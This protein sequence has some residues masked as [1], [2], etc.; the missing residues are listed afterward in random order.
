MTKYNNFFYIYPPRPKNAVEPND[1]D[2]WD[3]MGS[4]LGQVKLNG[5]NCVVFMNEDK[6]YV[7]NRH[8]NRLSNFCIE[9][10]EVRKLYKGS[11]W[12]VLNGEYLNKSKKDE[13]G[14][15]FNHKLVI[16]DILV[17]NGDYLIGKTFKQRVDLL[18]SLYGNDPCEKE[19]LHGITENTFRVKTY[20]G[21]F[22]ELFERFTKIDM[23]EGL[24]LKRKRSKLK[25][26]S[27]ADN[28]HKDQIKS[29][30]PTKNYSF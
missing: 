8:A 24:V 12:M 5:S 20:Y 6:T 13:T 27:N 3:G 23:I 25:V 15:S 1:L 17:Y 19:Y 22:K 26:G 10:E 28:N 29:R 18:D 14:S 2:F 9:I 4:M 7:Y 21:D 16:F 11:G 30:K